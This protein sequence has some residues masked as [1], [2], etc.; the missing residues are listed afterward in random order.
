MRHVADE[1]NVR[2]LKMRALALS[3][4]RD[5]NSGQTNPVATYR[6]EHP[7]PYSSFVSRSSGQFGARVEWYS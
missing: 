5:A 1:S 4:V 2:F 6:N 7:N 3:R